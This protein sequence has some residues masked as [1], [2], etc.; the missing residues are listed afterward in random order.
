MIYEV[1]NNREEWREAPG[2]DRWYE[3][4]SL[5][6]IRSWV[7]PGPRGAFGRP[8]ARK[9]PVLL[10]PAVGTHGYRQWCHRLSGKETRLSVHRTVCIAF[11][12]E[13]PAATSE[14]RHLDGDKLN[15]TAANLAWGFASDNAADRVRHGTSLAGERN[16]F[17]QLARADV[18][19]IR[20]AQR[21]MVKQM[22][23]RFGVSRATV[24]NVLAGKTW[25]EVL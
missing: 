12:G 18:A 11:H 16:P 8:Q 7:R 10:N 24:R 19:T 13:P 20:E 21:A 17:A 22:A 5:G 23:E 9:E 4:S 2:T 6:R 15:N 1:P 25:D 14:V 3:V